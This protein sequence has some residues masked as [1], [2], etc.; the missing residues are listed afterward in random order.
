[1]SKKNIET[2]PTRGSNYT[3]PMSKEQRMANILAKLCFS[4][5]GPAVNYQHIEKLVAQMRYSES[6]KAVD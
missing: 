1:M 3:P 6:H 5:H 4:S 2:T